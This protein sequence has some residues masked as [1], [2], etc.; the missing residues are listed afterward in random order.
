MRKTLGA[1]RLQIVVQFLFESLLLTLIALLVSL[2]LMYLAI[3]VYT[4]LTSTGFTAAMLMQS[5]FTLW[6]VLFVIVTGLISGLIPALVMSRFEPMNI[7]KGFSGRGRTSRLIRSGI[8]VVQFSL[9]TALVILAIGIAVQI[10][11]LSEMELGFNRSNL[12]VLDS[13][14]NPRAPEEFNYEAMADELA[15][16]PGV[17][18]VARSQV[19]PPSTGSYNPWQRPDWADD[20]MVPISHYAVDENY[21]DTFQLKLV[22]G[23]Q[24]SRDFGADFTPAG[25]PD[26]EQTYCVIITEAAVENFGFDS[27]EQALDNILIFRDSRFRIV[28]VINDFRLSGGMEDVLRSTS[29][30]RASSAPM[31]S[32]LI[33]IDP[34]RLEETL[35]HIDTVWSRHRPDIPVN[36]SFYEQTYDQLIYEQT[37]GISK[38]SLFAAII[39]ITIAALGLYALAFYSSQRR[40]KEVGVRKVLG[41]RSSSIIALL[42]WDFIKPVIIACLIAGVG[43]YFACSIQIG[44]PGQSAASFV[45]TSAAQL[46]DDAG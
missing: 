44:T 24:F 22:A 43:G 45:D 6:L 25:A 11:H 1:N 36:R 29:I 39:T 18:N 20:Q 40:T 7:I 14:H 27:A 21:I 3:P 19:P 28:G 5:S 35:A 46:N 15:Q 13:R 4:A 38:A 41:A 34:T 9:A 30:L 33:R 23:R 2:P 31:R 16:H 12:V 17:L 10:N 8:T 42:T 32:L 37:N 26:P